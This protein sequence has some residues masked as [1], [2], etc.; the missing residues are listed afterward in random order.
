MTK[1]EYPM[2][3][4]VKAHYLEQEKRRLAARKPDSSPHIKDPVERKQVEEVNRG[5]TELTRKYHEDAARQQGYSSAAHMAAH[6]KQ[7]EDQRVAKQ[8]YYDV[9]GEYG[10][11]PGKVAIEH[12]KKQAQ[13]KLENK[14]HT[15]YAW[16][17]KEVK[18]HTQSHWGDGKGNKNGDVK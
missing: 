15:D 7:L 18:E 3:K 10:R 2:D 13:A 17:A 8:G 16:S 11:K 1:E 4:E 12:N 14:P 5:I 6:K 9:G